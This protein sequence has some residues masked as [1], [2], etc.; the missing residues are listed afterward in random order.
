MRHLCH[1]GSDR[2]GCSFKPSATPATLDQTT[3][4][5]TLGAAPTIAAMCTR[6]PT[7]IEIRE[8]QAAGPG[9]LL[10]IVAFVFPPLAVN[11]RGKQLG[12]PCCHLPVI[13]TLILTLLGWLPGFIYSAYQL[14]RL[15][16]Y[17]H[18]VALMTDR[19]PPLRDRFASGQS[20]TH[21]PLYLVG[22][23]VERRAPRLGVSATQEHARG[24]GA[25]R[26]SA[27][28]QA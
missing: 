2:G 6:R 7:S 3:A 11:I 21:G 13:I 28:R 16:L 15:L 12:H 9:L 24:V 23:P 26:T 1:S 25:S 20:A 14:V 19:P 8:A 5:K 27:R 10:F 22:D 4:R 17:T 18:R